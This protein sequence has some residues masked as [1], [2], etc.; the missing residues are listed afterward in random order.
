[1]LTGSTSFLLGGSG[2]PN[3]TLISG[4]GADHD[5]AGLCGNIAGKNR[6]NDAHY[7]PADWP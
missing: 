2:Q 4:Y 5:R 7:L 6:I 3:F 1:M